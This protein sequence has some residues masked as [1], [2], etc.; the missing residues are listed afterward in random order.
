MLIA[1][2][3]ERSQVDSLISMLPKLSDDTNKIQVLNKLSSSYLNIQLDSGNIYARRAISLATNLGDKKGLADAYRSLGRILWQ[4]NEFTQSQY[5]YWQSL[6][7]YER[8]HDTIGMANSLHG[9]AINYF[10]QN[11]LLKAIEYYRKS[12]EMHRSVQNKKGEWGSLADIADAYETLKQYDSSITYFSQALHICQYIG[13]EQEVAYIS[14]R[15]GFVYAK[16]GNYQQALDLITKAL[17]VFEQLRLPVNLGIIYA[18]IA[19]IDLLE[20]QF[21]DALAYYQKSFATYSLVPGNY[22]ARMKAKN[23]V[24]AGQVYVQLAKESKEH[25]QVYLANATVSL[26]EAIDTCLSQH[27]I[28]ALRDG[29]ESLSEVQAMQGEYQASLVNYKRFTYYKDSINNIAK[30]EEIV[31]HELE[32]VYNK[33]KDSIDYITK[34]QQSELRKLSQE[35]E[36][37]TLRL[38]QQWLYSILIFLVLGIIVFYFLYRYRIKQLQLKNQLAGEKSERALIETEHQQQIN[39]AVLSALR[40]QMNPHFIF[41]ALNTIQSYVYA[42]DKRSAS[43]YLGKFSELI[44]RILDNSSKQTIT[45]QEEI[46]VL[47]LY[48]D[49]EKARFGESLHA[50]IEIAPDLNA[51]DIFIPPMLI[52]PYI[53]NAVK[54]GLLHKQGVKNLVVTIKKNIEPE[55]VEIVIDDNGIGRVMS[56]ELNKKRANHN[57]FAS[58][59]NNKRIALIEHITGKKAKLEIIDKKYRDGTAAGTKV[60]IHIPVGFSTVS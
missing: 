57:S 42:N 2:I 27:E 30:D 24:R 20:H 31:R 47:Q 41:N 5:S 19:E 59:A 15:L 29:Y 26:E 33:Q 12:F 21:Y 37:A 8:I 54:H 39:D 48:I 28:E 36:L 51:E 56:A 18:H 60:V 43:N 9:I 3:L 40:S 14:D 13:T 45:L 17:K 7:I 50:E 58:D 53:E 49:I 55:F 11:D 46:T 6:N 16:K 22:Y 35:K 34:L 32:Y 10:M 44:R 1:Q 25:R 52:Q 38:K 4:K 23:M